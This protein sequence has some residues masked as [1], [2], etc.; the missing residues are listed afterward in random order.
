MSQTPPPAVK[1]EDHRFLFRTLPHLINYL[2]LALSFGL[3]VFISYDTYRGVDY[4]E[5]SVY[6]GYQ[7]ICCV[8]FLVEYFYRLVINRHKWRFFFMALPFLLISIPYLNIIV[9]YNINVSREALL[10][11]CF[12][13]ILRGLFALIMVVSFI[14]K[15]ISTTVFYSYILVII[16]LVY[17]SGL[18]FYIA[19]KDVNAAVKNFWYALWFAGMNIT[20]IGCYINPMTAPGMIIGFFLSLLGLVMLPLFTVYCG[21]IFTTMNKKIKIAKENEKEGKA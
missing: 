10:Y 6:M 13:P 5:N 4:L 9:Y 11:L 16:P 21:D 12:I 1:A 20:T 17:M 15:K 19:E 14:A 3:I 7:L 18:I 2:V 8:I